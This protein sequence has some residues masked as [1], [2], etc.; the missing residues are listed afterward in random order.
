MQK[1]LK[2][3]I[4]FWGRARDRAVIRLFL[5]HYRFHPPQ[6]NLQQSGLI[7]ESIFSHLYETFYLE[8]SGDDSYFYVRLDL[9]LCLRSSIVCAPS[10]F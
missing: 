1:V 3:G 5:A 9:L 8:M 6:S 4:T 2:F 10:E 7:A